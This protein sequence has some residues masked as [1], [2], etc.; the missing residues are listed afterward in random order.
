MHRVEVESLVRKQGTPAGQLGHARPSDFLSSDPHLAAP[1]SLHTTFATTLASMDPT[2]KGLGEPTEK[3]DGSAL[4]VLIVHGQLTA[5]PSTH[6]A[7]S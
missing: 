3:F 2:V 5:H 1:P 7:R 6:R 4:R